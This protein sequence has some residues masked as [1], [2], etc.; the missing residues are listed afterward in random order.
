[1]NDNKHLHNKRNESNWFRII[2]SPGIHTYSKP[3]KYHLT[4]CEHNSFSF[5]LVFSTRVNIEYGSFFSKLLAKAQRFISQWLRGSCRPQARASDWTGRPWVRLGTGT[6][7][8]PK[9]RANSAQRCSLRMKRFPSELWPTYLYRRIPYA[10]EDEGEAEKVSHFEGQLWKMNI[11]DWEVLEMNNFEGELWKW[12]ISRDR[13][14]W[15]I[16]PKERQD[17]YFRRSMENT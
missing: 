11:F 3:I 12:I 14:G 17:N 16:I 2:S 1:M 15:W 9:T 10:P 6:P 13:F 4:Y 8:K 5:I 7:T